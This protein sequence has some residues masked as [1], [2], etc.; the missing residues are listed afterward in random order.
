MLDWFIQITANTFLAAFPIFSSKIV[1]SYDHLFFKYQRK[2]LI[3]RGTLIFQIFL[4]LKGVWVLIKCRYIERTINNPDLV[5]FQ[6][7]ESD[8][9]TR[10]KRCY[11]C[12]KIRPVSQFRSQQRSLKRNIKRLRS[13]NFG[14][15]RM[16]L[17]GYSPA[18]QLN[19]VVYSSSISLA[20]P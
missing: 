17:K 15:R 5:K 8:P 9:S 1:F 10:L 13:H 18:L 4:C 16:Y 11:L 12:Y 2:I 19:M 6:L 7:K 14:H 3:S 20:A